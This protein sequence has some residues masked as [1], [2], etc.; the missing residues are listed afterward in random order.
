[1]N[2]WQAMGW[3]T[4]QY[5]SLIYRKLKLLYMDQVRKDIT[6]CRCQCDPTI[7]IYH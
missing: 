6:Q 4:M 2:E 5:K 7:K 3:K 1:M